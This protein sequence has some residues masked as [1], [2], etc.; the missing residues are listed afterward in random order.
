LK[1]LFGHWELRVVVEI[2]KIVEIKVIVVVVVVDVW[3]D[4]F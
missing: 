4:D 1:G 3:I 2:V